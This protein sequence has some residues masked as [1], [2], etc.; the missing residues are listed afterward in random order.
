MNKPKKQTET[1][2]QKEQAKESKNT[3][4]KEQLA[5]ELRAYRKSKR[6]SA[7]DLAQKSGLSPSFI[8]LIETGKVMPSV[9]KFFQLCRA[10]NVSPAKFYFTDWNGDKDT[11]ELIEIYN[12]LNQKSANLLLAVAREL[13]KA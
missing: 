12:T 5:Q 9:E 11:M 6:M 4:F 7:M 3:N 10:L 13:N 8:S 2:Y 1:L